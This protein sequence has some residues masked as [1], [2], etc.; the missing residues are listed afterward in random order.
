MTPDDIREGYKFAAA[1]FHLGGLRKKT[2]LAFMGLG[3]K[4]NMGG[5]EMGTAGRAVIANLL[6]PTSESAHRDD[7]ERDRLF[8]IQNQG[9]RLRWTPENFAKSIA[10]TYGVELSKEARA[11]LQHVFNNK[12][13]VADAAKFMPAVMNVLGDALSTTTPIEKEH[14]RPGAPTAT[15]R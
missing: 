8:E 4:A 9:S 13:V 11:S 3:K 1:P 6:K 14:R 5:D 2:M 15:P 10:A 12:A 7:G